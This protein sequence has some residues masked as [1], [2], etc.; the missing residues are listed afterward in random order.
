MKVSVIIPVYCVENY[1]P[2]CVDSV[3]N[4]S[5]DDIEVILVND[6]SPDS[7][8]DICDRYAEKYANV[9]AVH[10]ENGGLSDARNK[11]VEYATGEYILFLDGDDFWDDKD[12][13]KK[14]IDRIKLTKADVLNLSFKKYNDDTDEK[15]PYFENVFDMPLEYV[16]REEQFN[17][18]TE[19]NLYIS[20]ACTKMIKRELFS[21]GLSFEKGVYSEDVEWSAR[22][23]NIADTMDFIPLDFYCYRQRNNSISHTIN[24]KKCQDLCKHIITCITLAINTDAYE[25]NALSKYA[26]F[27]YGTYFIV[28]AQAENWQQEC[29]NRLDK[30]KSILSYHNNNKKLTAL[31]YAVKIIGYKNVCR[32]VRFLYRI[33]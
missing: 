24:D 8:P 18:I 3:L 10:K 23:L 32:I 21:K 9:I 30:Y 27:Q 28:Q 5:Y 26:A 33:K 4:Q 6:G 15:S 14:M 16:H 13:I 29:I 12:A 1:L 2:Q 31:Y 19:N 22:L 25:K 20:S 7:C 11:G 17:Y